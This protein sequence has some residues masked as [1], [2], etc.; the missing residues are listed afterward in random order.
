MTFVRPHSWQVPKQ[1]LAVT[2][3]F[4]LQVSLTLRVLGV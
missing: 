1:G 4:G 2:Q 3:V